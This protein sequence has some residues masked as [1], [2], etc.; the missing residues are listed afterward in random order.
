[1][2]EKLSELSLKLSDMNKV[3]KEHFGNLKVNVKEKMMITL[4]KFGR[5]GDEIK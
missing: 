5:M 4:G 1:M 2:G 3:V